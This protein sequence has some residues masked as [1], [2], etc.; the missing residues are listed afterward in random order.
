LVL[1]QFRNTEG[2]LAWRTTYSSE[3]GRFSKRPYVA[4]FERPLTAVV[5]GC[6]AKGAIA[7]YDVP[8]GAP[9]DGT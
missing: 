6:Q 5:G 4:G 1:L 9:I 3:D 8:T 2:N 7:E